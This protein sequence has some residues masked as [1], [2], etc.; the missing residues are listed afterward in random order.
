MTLSENIINFIIKQNIINLIIKQKTILG[1]SQWQQFKTLT[2]KS[3]NDV[4]HQA[5]HLHQGSYRVNDDGHLPDKLHH[6]Q[7]TNES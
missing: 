1:C 3:F 7:A 2:Y 5:G 6:D 4:L